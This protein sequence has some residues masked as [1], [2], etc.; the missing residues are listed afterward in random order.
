M[1]TPLPPATH[2]K[3]PQ[4]GTYSSADELLADDRLSETQKQIA[5]EAWRIQLEHGMSEEADPAPFKAAV[6]SLKGAADRLA[7]GQH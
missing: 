7:A 3:H 6:K 5:I 1:Q 4:L 2:Y